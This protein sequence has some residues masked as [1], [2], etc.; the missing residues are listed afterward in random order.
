MSNVAICFLPRN[1][2]QLRGQA[3]LWSEPYDRQIALDALA[4]LKRIW[5]AA[6]AVGPAILPALP[7][8]DSHCQHCGWFDATS[9]DP[10][11]ACPGHPS[12]GITHA[13]PALSLAGTR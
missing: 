13:A 3:Y 5:D 4:R 1:A 10:T 2:P 8:A 11:I 9:T 6:S 7:T 12:A